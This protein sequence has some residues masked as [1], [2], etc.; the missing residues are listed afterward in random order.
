M[1][2]SSVVPMIWRNTSANRPSAG[3]VLPRLLAVLLGLAFH[4]SQVQANTSSLDADRWTCQVN[5][6]AVHTIVFNNGVISEGCDR[7]IKRLHAKGANHGPLLLVPNPFSYTTK[8][9][10][11][12]GR[13][14]AGRE[15]ERV[16]VVEPC[17]ST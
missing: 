1:V 9:D 3:G 11:A 7:Q 8:D 15:Q 6:F 16:Y 17:L 10:L 13:K 14:D 2:S 4:I 5:R 12:Q